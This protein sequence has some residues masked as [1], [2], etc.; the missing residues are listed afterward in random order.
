LKQKPTIAI[1]IALVLT[2][3]AAISGGA[4]SISMREKLL[5]IPVTAK[6]GG[7]TTRPLNAP[8]A[9]SFQAANAPREHQRAFSFGNRLFNTNWVEAP[10]S[11]KSF[12][13][14]GPLFNRVSCSGC[15]TKD[16]RGTPPEIGRD[17][18]IGPMN[19]ML[20]RL[21][22]PG[23]NANGGPK[24]L[25]G[26]GDQLSERGINT[27]APEGLAAITYKEIEGQYADGTPYSLRSPSYTIQKLAYG[28]LPADVMISPRVAPHMIGLGLL[29]AVPSETLLGLADPNDDDKD[30]IS[31]RVNRVWDTVRQQ[32]AFGRFGW[33]AGQPD[34]IN[35]N[36]SAALGDLGI[37]SRHHAAENCTQL[38]ANCMT[39]INGGSPE[40]SDAFLEKLTLYTATLAVPAQRD[41]QDL[42]VIEGSKIFRSIGCAGC[43]LP[44]LQAGPHPLPEI[45]NQTF[46][47]Y[48]D[49]LL[50]DMGEALADNRP[51]FGANGQEWRTPPLWGL[52]LLMQVNDHQNLLHD[53]RAR[54]FA[55]AI[56]WHGGEAEA[57]KQRFK[58]ADKRSRDALIKYLNSL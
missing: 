14:L 48:T 1:F 50:H 35:Q 20:L 23:T 17:T 43:H 10:A 13:G 19:S 37:T 54:G 27:F 44:T 53:G 40:L 26:Y 22:V 56:L 30:G 9:F 28:E 12:D 3:L 39:A 32:T 25:P 57:A 11:V 7:D 33:K 6:L 38:Q 4:S 45:A 36:S 55:E 21:S 16:G 42:D 47:P 18:A 8:N 15:H 5:A 34:L 2:G 46:H 29:E 49:L 41:S 58:Q 51:E 24:P 31:G 52:G